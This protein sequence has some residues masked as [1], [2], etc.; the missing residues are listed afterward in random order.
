MFQ[1]KC[2][3]QISSRADQSSDKHIARRMDMPFMLT[4][5]TGTMFRLEVQRFEP[6]A[7]HPMRIRNG[8]VINSTLLT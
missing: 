5:P 6:E 2:Q 3:A 1:G 7:T 8:M 4:T